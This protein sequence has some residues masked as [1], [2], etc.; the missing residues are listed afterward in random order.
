MKTYKEFINESHKVT[1]HVEKG[2]TIHSKHN[3]LKTAIIA[4]KKLGN[5]G[6]K[7]FINHVFNNQLVNKTDAYGRVY[8][9]LIKH[10]YKHPTN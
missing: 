7:T 6:H 9:H 5:Y 3:D 4:A 1:Y 8:R 2:D 10:K